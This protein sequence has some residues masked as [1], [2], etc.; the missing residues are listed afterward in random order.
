MA[1][2]L[3]DKPNTEWIVVPP[4]NNVAFV[5]YATMQSFCSLF[6]FKKT[7]NGFDDPSHDLCFSYF[8]DTSYI[9]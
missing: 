9:L 2:L 3:M 8:Y 5:V 4:N 1:C 7:L 6:V